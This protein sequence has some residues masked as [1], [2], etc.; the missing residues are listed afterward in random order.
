MDSLHCVQKGTYPKMA[1]PAKMVFILT[2]LGAGM[3]IGTTTKAVGQEERP[4]EIGYDMSGWKTTKTP[5]ICQR[6]VH[7]M[8]HCNHCYN[9][10]RK[11][12]NNCAGVPKHCG[13]TNGIVDICRCY[14][15]M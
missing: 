4:Q 9:C 8:K 12:E 7:R 13:T 11:Y 2:I 3:I 10:L 1:F 15:K 6:S 5:G 14:R